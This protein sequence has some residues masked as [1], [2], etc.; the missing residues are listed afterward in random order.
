MA[1]GRMEGVSSIFD[2]RAINEEW[3]KNQDVF[4]MFVE[5]E[6]YR[7]IGDGWERLKSDADPVISW[8][9]ESLDI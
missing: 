4:A 6:R 9:P 8:K 2:W 7:V 3:G 1:K 5:D